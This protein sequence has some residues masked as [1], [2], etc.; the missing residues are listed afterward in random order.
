MTEISNFHD[1]LIIVF[2]QVKVLKIIYA[3]QSDF[4]KPYINFNTEKRTECSK[5]KDK[6]VADQC[7]SRSNSKFGEQIENKKQCK[8][9]KIANT[10]NKA[11]KFA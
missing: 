4:M 2:H 10:S 8:D 11:K 7:K 5:N 3:K 9:V 6:F 1:Y